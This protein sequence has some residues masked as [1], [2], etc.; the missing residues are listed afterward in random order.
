MADG[1]RASV[2]A[3]PA[4][5]YRVSVP[6][7]PAVLCLGLGGLFGYRVLVRRAA[8]KIDSASAGAVAGRALQFA[9]LLSV[10]AALT[11]VGGVGTL[12]GV[13]SFQEFGA[14]LKITG[15]LQMR[16]LEAA[17][18]ITHKPIK[19]TPEEAAITLW[20]ETFLSNGFSSDPDRQAATETAMRKAFDEPDPKS[21][22]GK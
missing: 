17:C 15:P 21:G 1:A 16:R 2:P 13:N 5:L 3:A 7:A 14:S 6:A 10:S 22:P 9:S 18:G 4:A 11:L 20:L 8:A 12:M 19:E